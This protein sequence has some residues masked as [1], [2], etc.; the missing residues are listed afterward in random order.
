MSELIT[1]PGNNSANE[2]SIVH[3][4][5]SL[6]RDWVMNPWYLPDLYFYEVADEIICRADFNELHNKLQTTLNETKDGDLNANLTNGDTRREPAS[7][8][9]KALP[10]DYAC[11]SYH[12]PREIWYVH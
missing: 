3:L 12:V 9:D 8:Y 1:V 6:L 11:F 5:R 7:R 2:R 10:A 4:F